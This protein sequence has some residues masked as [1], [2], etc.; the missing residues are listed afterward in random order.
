MV[1][2][3]AASKWCQE[4]DP[5]NIHKSSSCANTCRGFNSSLTMFISP[6]FYNV[7]SVEQLSHNNNGLIHDFHYSCAVFK[8]VFLFGSLLLA[9]ATCITPQSIKN[10]L[11]VRLVNTAYTW[12]DY[13]GICVCLCSGPDCTADSQ[14]ETNHL[15]VVVIACSRANFSVALRADL[16]ITKTHC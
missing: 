12:V 4:F 1:K 6:N 13:N 3:S 11:S 10:L 2:F 5:K 14:T 9:W 7:S 8:S 16:T 15:A